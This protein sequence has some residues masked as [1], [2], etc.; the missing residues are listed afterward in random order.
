VRKV[1]SRSAFLEYTRKLQAILLRIY[2]EPAA[3]AHA[4]RRTGAGRHCPGPEQLG[5]ECEI[6]RTLLPRSVVLFSA[7]P[8][9]GV[10]R[11]ETAGEERR[12]H[13]LVRC[14]RLPAPALSAVYGP[15]RGTADD[16]P[17]P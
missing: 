6:A 1:S 14:F 10:Q 17:L 11:I 12:S 5:V 13:L 3:T 15:V 7:P 4:W 16:L 2:K 8:V 9:P